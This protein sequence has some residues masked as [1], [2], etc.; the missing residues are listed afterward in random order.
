METLS[1]AFADGISIAR[2]NVIKVIRVP[3]ILVAVLVTP[4]I[5]VLMFAYVF[6]GSI[7]IPGG[8]YPEFLVAGAFAL[9]LAFGATLTGAGLADDMQKGIIDRFRSLPMS[10]SAVVFGRTASDVIYNVASLVIMAGAGLIVGWRIH[11]GV[12][13]ALM[14]FGA[15]V[16]IALLAFWNPDVYGVV[17]PLDIGVLAAAFAGALAATALVYALAWRDGAAPARLVARLTAALRVRTLHA[18]VLRRAS[19]R[20]TLRTGADAE[21]TVLV[22]G[23]GGSYPALTMAVGERAGLIGALNT[24]ALRGVAVDILLPEKNNLKLVQWASSALS[25][26]VLDRGCR[27]W[28][29]PPPFDHTKLFLVDDVWS[30][31][32]SSNWDARSLRLNFEYNVECYDEG[33]AREV[34]RE[35]RRAAEL[36]PRDFAPFTVLGVLERELATWNPLLRGFAGALFGGLPA[37]CRIAAAQEDVREHSPAPMRE[38]FDAAQLDDVL[39]AHGGGRERLAVHD[40]RRARRPRVGLP[41]RTRRPVAAESDSPGCSE[42]CGDPARG[43]H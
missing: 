37:A 2:R 6:G 13:N 17:N 4:I 31:I 14:G 18:T 16:I 39:P 19:A 42:V 10:R 11:N 38:R 28:H 22:A 33:L 9:N 7:D 12:G 5:M 36:D 20:V 3:Q 24:T 15:F 34:G 29:S 8:S 35:A 23:R 27:I 1:Y 32:G 30:L 26:Q 43:A 25:W 41:A 21:T 40:V